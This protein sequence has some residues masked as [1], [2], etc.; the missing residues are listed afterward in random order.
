MSFCS[1]FEVCR[2]DE[3]L[4]CL[5][6]C[7]GFGACRTGELFNLETEGLVKVLGSEFDVQRSIS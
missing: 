2:I 3:S 6:D 1:G 4:N 7:S 5:I